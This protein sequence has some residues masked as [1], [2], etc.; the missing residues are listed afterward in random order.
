MHFPAG[1]I[2]SERQ[3]EGFHLEED[4]QSL[5]S[6]HNHV[7]VRIDETRVSTVLQ[8]RSHN[9]AQEQD[10]VKLLAYIQHLNIYR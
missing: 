10:W 6:G 1:T 4:C 8:R 3:T 7:P 9:E 2:R 5:T